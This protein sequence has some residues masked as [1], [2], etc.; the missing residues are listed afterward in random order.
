MD[1]DNEK[2]FK[3][4][5]EIVRSMS[6]FDKDVIVCLVGQKKAGKSMTINTTA[7]ALTG[8]D[9]CEVFTLTKSSK[10]IDGGTHATFPLPLVPGL[11][12]REQPGLI[13]LTDYYE[14][15]TRMTGCDSVIYTFSG[16]Q[17]S[18]LESKAEAIGKNFSSVADAVG[19]RNHTVVITGSETNSNGK[20]SM[21]NPQV[22]K[23]VNALDCEKNDVI[24][25]ENETND[26][27]SL[28]TK[29]QLER[30]HLVEQVYKKGRANIRTQNE[31]SSCAVM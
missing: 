14:V 27:N 4:R 7:A 29:Q 11:T 20:L 6:Q 10:L 24:F 2:L 25:I 26:D 22:R 15:K 19:I 12:I 13:D 31:K 17:L 8:G 23:V 16:A 1:K 18:Q 5:E 9:P 21:S 30:I 3:R 28:S